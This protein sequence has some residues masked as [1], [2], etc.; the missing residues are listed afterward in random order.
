MSNIKCNI[1]KTERTNRIVIGAII[2][3]AA[4]FGMGWLFFFIVGIILI[5][6]GIIGWCAIPHLI[7]KF[8]K[9]T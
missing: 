3:L 1:D 2:A 9:R 7:S 6:E 5:V 8:K 4:L